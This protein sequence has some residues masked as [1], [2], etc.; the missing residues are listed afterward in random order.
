MELLSPLAAA[1]LGLGFALG[2]AGAATRFCTMGAIS[3][4]V[5][6]RDDNRLRAWALAIAVALAVSQGL[7]LA[8]GV[9]LA[10]SLYR[11]PN[12]SWLGAILGG[13]LFGIGMVLAGGCGFRLLLRAGAGSLRAIVALQ[14]LGLSSYAALHGVFA[15]GRL[16][17]ERVTALDLRGFGFAGQG[18][19]ELFGGALAPALVAVVLT[20]ALA[21]W[22]VSKGA[23]RRDLRC[24]AGG[25]AVGLLVAMAWGV[26]AW[27]GLDEFD[28]QPPRSLS[29][30][31]PIGDA[32]AYIMTASGTTFG[33]TAASVLGT[34]LGAAALAAG[35]RSFTRETAIEGRDLARHLLGGGL[36]G[37]GGVLALGC[38]VGQGITAL[39]TLAV[40][41]FLVLPAI[42]AGAFATLKKTENS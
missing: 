32:A 12:V 34:L 37:V 31:A 39:S 21:G 5:L 35:T 23:F 2:L 40:T 26:T 38:T 42:F 28:P 7:E 27:A 20:A 6:K 11:G 8:G 36:M 15:H 13:A 30:V 19:A 33:F 24:W 3:D 16:W 9:P 4:L 41:P 18:L 22:A 1:G 10:R 29:F 14:A 25:L 17:L